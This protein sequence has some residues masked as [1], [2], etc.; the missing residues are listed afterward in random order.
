MSLKYL[1]K[2]NEMK[3]NSFKVISKM[4]HVDDEDKVISE[5][6]SDSSGDKKEEILY[7]HN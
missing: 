5:E 6:F 7:Q 2:L 3:N 4:S 1:I